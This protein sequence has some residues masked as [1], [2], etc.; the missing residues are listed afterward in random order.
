[1]KSYIIFVLLLLAPTCHAQTPVEVSPCD[2]VQHPQTYDNKLI[3]IRDRVSIAFEDFSLETTGC[4]EKFRSVWLAYGG[5]EPTPT[6]STVNDQ[7]RAPG[8]VVKVHGRSISLVHDDSLELFKR[9]LSAVRVGVPGG[10]LYEVTATLT[11]VFFAA[12]QDGGFGH[13]HCCHLFVIQKVDAVE[14]RRT[15]VP[16]GGNLPPETPI[17]C[18]NLHSDFAINKSD[19]ANIAK[20]VGSGKETWR[21]ASEQQAS[22]E[23][24]DDA[25]RRWNVKLVSGLIFES[26]SNRMVVGGDQF[27]WCTWTDPNSMQSFMIQVTRFGY[28]RHWRDWNSVP[29]ILTRGAGTACMADDK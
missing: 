8:S 26:C 19:A 9:R 17:G 3:Q 21:L 10:N 29:W 16:A 22:R 5:D 6:M 1:M 12:S 18:R 13:L 24:L 4:G 15:S 28:L 23:A 11:G 2:L 7:S 14:A 27:T 20:S 25:A